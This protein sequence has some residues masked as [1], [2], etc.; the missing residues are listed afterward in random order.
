MV[1]LENI[2]EEMSENKIENERLYYI[3]NTVGDIFYANYWKK[4]GKGH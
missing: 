1:D 4:E 2:I 3:V